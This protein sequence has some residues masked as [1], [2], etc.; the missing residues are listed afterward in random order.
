M[1]EITT[2]RLLDETEKQRFL[3]SLQGQGRTSQTVRIA[4]NSRMV[5]RCNQKHRVGSAGARADGG[6]AAAHLLH[7]PKIL[8]HSGARIRGCAGRL[9]DN[10][11]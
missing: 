8:R 7:P 4:P 5:A 2:G 6:I 3:A 10:T 11:R 9:A 1:I